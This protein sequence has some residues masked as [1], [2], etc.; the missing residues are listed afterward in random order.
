M[1]GSWRSRGRCHMFGDDIQHDNGMIPFHHV[2]ERQT[3]PK[4][5][6]PDL[7]SAVDPEFKNRVQPGDFIIGGQ[8][9]GGGKGHTT[10]YIAMEGLGLRVLCESTFQRVIRGGA[11]LGL[12]IMG[13]CKEITKFIKT[14]DEIEVDMST[15]EVTNLSSGW[16][17]TYPPIPEGVRK[18]VENGGRKGFL[19]N[20]LLEHPQPADATEKTI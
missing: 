3:D 6:I 11:N 14:G 4:V 12:P 15:G 20:W 9:F 16:R 18:I 7:L 13:D 5:L 17:A 19:K 2:H 1:Q 8:R 10:A